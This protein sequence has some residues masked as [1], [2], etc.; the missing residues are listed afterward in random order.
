MASIKRYLHLKSS[1]ALKW[2]MRSRDP[3]LTKAIEVVGSSYKLA[4]KIGVSP[5][6]LSQ[7]ERVPP[8]R[9]LQVEAATN[10]KISRHDLRPD[11]YPAEQAVA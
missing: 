2:G 3:A 5:Q 4:R 8:L 10:N 11:L 6:A 9:V 1:R 7:W